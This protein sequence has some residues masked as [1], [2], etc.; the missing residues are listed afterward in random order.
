M[1]P[2]FLRD[3]RQFLE[4]Q[5]GVLHV[6]QRERDHLVDD[7]ERARTLAANFGVRVDRKVEREEP[8]CCR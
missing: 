6:M 2:A 4:R 7:I 3:E 1:D 5:W 8:S